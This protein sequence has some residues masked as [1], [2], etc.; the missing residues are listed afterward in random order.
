M[1]R[2]GSRP[3]QFQRSGKIEIKVSKV[4]H[5]AQPIGQ[6]GVAPTGMLRGDHAKPPRQQFEPLAVRLQP[7]ARVQEQQRRPVAAFFQLKRDVSS[8]IDRDMRGLCAP[9]AWGSRTGRRRPVVEIEAPCDKV[10][11]RDGEIPR[12]AKQSSRQV[13]FGATRNRC[14]PCWSRVRQA[15]ARRRPAA[16]R[17]RCRPA[18]G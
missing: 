9:E 7:L 4:V 18:C 11:A 6:R 13:A 10:T 1:R 12:R 5:R 2:R 14:W 8:E 16:A 3:L 17:W 15:A